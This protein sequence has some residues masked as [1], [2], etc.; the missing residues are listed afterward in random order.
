MPIAGVIYIAE[1]YADIRPR[2]GQGDTAEGGCGKDHAR[3]LGR[4]VLG[5][6]AAAAHILKQLQPLFIYLVLGHGLAGLLHQ[7]S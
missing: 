1:I 2:H 7:R 3:A 5:H 6:L 4:S